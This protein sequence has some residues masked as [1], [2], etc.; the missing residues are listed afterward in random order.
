M[1][2][3]SIRWHGPRTMAAGGAVAA[4]WRGR[5]RRRARGRRRAKRPPP[6]EKPVPREKPAPRERAAPREKPRRARGS[7]ARE[8]SASRKPRHAKSSA[9][10]ARGEAR[11]RAASRAAAVTRSAAPRAAPA[12][13]RSGSGRDG[14]RRR[15]AGLHAAAHTRR[16]EAG[17]R[18]RETARHEVHALPVGRC[19]ASRPA[20][21]RR[22]ARD[23]RRRARVLPGEAV[24]ARD[25]GEPAREIPSRDHERDGRDGLPRRHARGLRL[26]RR[27]LRQL[28]ADR[29]RGGARRFRLSLGVLGAVVAGDVS[30]LGFRLRGAAAEISAEAAQRRVG[31]LLR[32]DR[33]GCRAPIPPRCARGRSASMAAMC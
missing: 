7:A 21:D 8:G 22:G 24:P 3:G 33:T 32:P 28:R 5:R 10:G 2:R 29:A 11:A 18:R 1:S 30:D 23:P 19:A 12:R 6:R 15:T 26:R 13:R 17:D 31:R 14:F 20:V 4:G 27:Q 16:G 25:R 9:A